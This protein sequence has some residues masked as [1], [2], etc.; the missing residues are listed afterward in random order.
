MYHYFSKGTKYSGRWH[1]EGFTENIRAVG[2]YYLHIDDEL[3]GGAL[4]FRPSKA[5]SQY[6][7][8]YGNF[9]INRYMMPET[10]TAIVFD[11][12][13]PHRFCSIRNTTFIA[14]RRTF[15][16]FFVVCLRHPINALSISDLPL[17]SYEQC[18]ALLKN[19]ENDNNQQTLPDL[20]ILKILSFLQKTMWQT[21][22]DAKEFRTRSRNEMLNAKSG[23]AGIHYG[24]SGDILFIKSEYE[25]SLKKQQ[26]RYRDLY[27][28]LEHTE[29]D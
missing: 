28:Q 27:N 25:L 22:M 16:N 24:N 26:N 3:E 5:P 4:K 9:D 1:T 18:E 23:W 21:D 13:L 29:S 10:D 8:E 15:L 6:Y 19:I 20:V 17:I 14:R 11:N 7:A 12:C 2:V